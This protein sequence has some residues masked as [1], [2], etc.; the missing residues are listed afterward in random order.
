[1]TEEIIDFTGN[2]GVFDGFSKSQNLKNDYEASDDYTRDKQTEDFREQYAPI[3]TKETAKYANDDDS[4][5]IS[6]TLNFAKHLAIGTA[7]GV[8]EV[9]QTFRLLDDDAWNLPK[10][11]T[12]A[13]SLAQGFGQ[14]LP[15]FIPIAG[16]VG[17]GAQGARLVARARL[18]GI[19]GSTK[20]AKMGV[21]FLV[22]TAAGAGADAIAFDPKDPNAANFLLV[23]GAIGHDSSAGVA[24]KALLAQDNSDTEAIARMKSSAT[25][26]IAGAIV[27]G[28]FKGAGWAYKGT[29][30]KNNLPKDLDGI[31]IKEVKEMAQEEAENYTDG[32][33][34]SKG[35]PVGDGPTYK[36]TPEG[37]KRFGHDI[38]SVEAAAKEKYRGPQDD[39]VRPWDQLSPDK[40]VQAGKIVSKW[41][42]TGEVGSHDLNIIESMNFLKLKT[43]EDIKAVMQFLSE[44]MNIKSILKG[45]VKTEDF[46]TISGAADMLE[47]PEEH[48]SRIVEGQANNVRNAIK[49]VGVARA[50]GAAAFKKAEDAF[51]LFAN[52][53]KDELY[54]EGLSATKLAYDFLA[55]GGELS[56]AS[57][58]LLRSHQKLI[59]AAENLSDIKSSLRHSILYNDPELSIKQAGWFANTRKV[60]KLKI[61]AKFPGGATRTT[62]I[63][64]IPGETKTQTKA[65]AVKEAK[66]GELADISRANR[67]QAT[68][69]LKAMNKSFYGKTRDTLLEVYINGLLSSVKTYEVN[70]LGN[71]TAIVTSIIDRAY[72]GMVKRGGTIQGQEA[73]ELAKSYWNSISSLSDL[74]NLMKKSWDLE[75]HANIKQDFIRPHDRAISAEAM[76]IGNPLLAKSINVF[77][78]IVNFPGRILLSADEVFKT[79]NYRAEVRALAYRKAFREVTETGANTNTVQGKVATKNKFNEIMKDVEAHDDIV[80]EAKGFAAKNTFT[81]PLQSHVVKG[82]GNEKDKIVKGLGLKLKGILDADQTGIA[83]VFIPFF[84]TPANLLNFAWER[85]PFIRKWNRGLQHELSKDAPSAVRELAE[86]KIATSR[87]LW[88]S[89]MGLAL[90]GNFTGGPPVDPNLRKTLEAAMGGSHWYSYKTNDGWIKYD[91]FDPIGVIMAASAHAAVMGKAAMN[92][93]GQREKG[94]PSDEIHDKFLEV[95]EAG[96]VGMVR[97][98]TDRHY[99]QGFSE[100]LNIFSGD[101]T[102]LTK[103]RKLGEKVVKAGDVRSSFYSSFRRNVTG[104]LEPEKLTKLQRTELRDLEDVGKEIG[105]IFEEAMR[106]V[107][108]G[109]GNKRAM[110]NLA[111]ETTLFP[112]TNYEIDTEPFQVLNNLATTVLNPIPTITP[113]K[114]PLIQKLAALESTIRQPSSVNKLNGILISDEEKSFFIDVWTD[115]NK[116]LNKRVVSSQF[117]KLPE[118]TQR[119]LL[120]TMIENNKKIARKK[121]MFKF[122]RIRDAAIENKIQSLHSKTLKQVPTG[123]NIPNL[124]QQ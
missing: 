104:G 12:T 117:N 48:M 32:I 14:F 2:Q 121:T 7:K 35:I 11:S 101:G 86:A 92:L 23:S 111:G 80:E 16:W 72:A 65:R 25:G 47:I 120:E 91:R 68:S 82:V 62:F 63:K 30:G 58:D 64:K 18:A 41:A 119:T 105:I 77:G 106:S 98:I 96:T 37:F 103:M 57:S 115:L 56:K 49:Y 43:S 107:T 22:G 123:F 81:N 36:I 78:A 112:G 84:Q 40:K 45:R 60:D 27:T 116:R 99:L 88:V 67:K 26:I 102:V 4:G 75:P 20:K 122:P 24:V 74:W 110:K 59:S 31:P 66:R 97:L 55:A 89:T 1:M 109:Y 71:S 13:E 15:A 6:S 52:G 90:T 54:D 100:M 28:L 85:T 76:R 61:Q 70:F 34:R 46:D 113:S 8:E 108:P 79:I 69:R 33:L 87:M 44:K 124:G 29:L 53:G 42:E 19:T 83:R 39:Y 114:S 5:F 38:P 50:M 17:K 21:D 51:E 73:A 118:G 94:D 3:A 9:G 93:A 95:L 10:P